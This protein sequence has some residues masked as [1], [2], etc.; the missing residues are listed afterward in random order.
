MNMKVFRQIAYFFAVALFAMALVSCSNDN[1]TVLTTQQDNI[2]RYLTSSHQPKLI[3]ES[4]I[5][6]SLDNEPQFYTNWGLDIYRYIATYYDEGRED[7]A[8]VE[9]GSKI[10]ITYRAYIFSGSKPS[11]DNLFATNDAAT[12]A[13]LESK[14]LNTSY[15]WSTEPLV[16]TMGRDEILPGLETALIGCSEGDSVEIYLTY[17][18]A[19]GKHYVGFVPAKSAVMWFINIDSVL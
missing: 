14:G 11:D 10:A 15:E 2:S 12:I 17:N 3:P 5:P 19:Y 1:D 18:A 6:N 8:V 7:K 13:D 16:V 9:R 4:E